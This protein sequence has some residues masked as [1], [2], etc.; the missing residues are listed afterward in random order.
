M[1]KIKVLFEL[2]EKLSLIFHFLS[3][4]THQ[5]THSS[6]IV[7]AMRE[8]K[9]LLVSDPELCIILIFQF[10]HSIKEAII[11]PVLITVF[12]FIYLDENFVSFDY[13][14]AYGNSSILRLE[15]HWGF[16]FHSQRNS[17]LWKPSS[18]FYPRHVQSFE[19]CLIIKYR[20][21]FHTYSCRLLCI[22]SI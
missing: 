5:K 19:L 21:N 9:Q 4:P 2:D 18:S 7:F 1:V 12:W 14:S 22:I 8:S 16:R 13:P 15:K 3:T 11:C 10:S 20:I 6:T 17:S